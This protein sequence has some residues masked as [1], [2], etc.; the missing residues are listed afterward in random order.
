MLPRNKNKEDWKTKTPK[1]RV[2]D[3]NLAKH[4]VSCFRPKNLPNINDTPRAAADARASLLLLLLLHP[5]PCKREYRHAD[6]IGIYGVC[7][8]S[9]AEYIGGVGIPGA[10]RI[11]EFLQVPK[12]S[13]LTAFPLLA[14]PKPSVSAVFPLHP[15]PET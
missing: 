3:E 13:V 14:V 4:R 1:R 12:P 8:A 2:V 5:S 11:H 15:M 7:L 9:S 6:S 10:L